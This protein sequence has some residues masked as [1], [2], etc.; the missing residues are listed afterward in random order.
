MHT[1]KL[2]V[3]KVIN[4]TPVD[5]LTYAFL[6]LIHYNAHDVFFCKVVVIL[7]E[8][9]CCGQSKRQGPFYLKETNNIMPSC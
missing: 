8:S 1:K 2:A 9:C 7:Y 4:C 5:N 6:K 3:S